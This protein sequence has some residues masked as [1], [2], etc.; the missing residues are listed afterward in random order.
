MVVGNIKY[1]ILSTCTSASLRKIVVCVQDIR[2]KNKKVPVG[3]RLV[4]KP[5]VLK[6]TYDGNLPITKNPSTST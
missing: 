3:P 2:P 1:W 6:C 4:R 5:D